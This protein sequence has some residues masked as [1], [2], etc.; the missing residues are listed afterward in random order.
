MKV[1]S[2]FFGTH[3]F[4]VA[5]L[6]GLAADPRL[7][8][9]A[10]VTQPDR[11]AGRSGQLQAPPVKNF[12]RARGLD[13]I[14]TASLKSAGVSLPAADVHIVAQYGLIIPQPVLDCPRFGTLNVHTSL[15]PKY[16]GAAPI[17]AAILRG[18]TVTGVTVMLMDAGLDTGPILAQRQVGIEPDDT[19][20]IMDKKLALTGR[21]LLLETLPRYLSGEIKPRPQDETQASYAPK[22][23]RDSGRINWQSGTAEI[24]NQYRAYH[25]WPGVWTTWNGQRLKILDLKPSS[26][27]LPAGAASTEAGTLHVGCGGHALEISSLQLEGKRPLTAHEFLSGYGAQFQGATLI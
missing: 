27:R 8:V 18:E 10:V 25:P 2:I 17:Q 26:R 14:Q 9:I 7:A 4:A 5:I 24:Y 12:A 20:Q 3:E 23:D 16:R 21:D 1:K 6:E 13:V 22:L 15:L 19:Y 11:P